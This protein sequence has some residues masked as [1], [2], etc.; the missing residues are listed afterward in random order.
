MTVFTRKTIITIAGFASIFLAISINGALSANQKKMPPAPAKPQHPVVSVTQVAAISKQAEITAYGEVSSRN[1]LSITS[2]VDG[3]IVYISPKFLTGNTFNQGEVLLEIEPIAYQQ[4]LADALVTLAD[5]ELVLAQEQLNSE[6]AKEEWLQSEL[7]TEQASDLVLRKPQ[8][9]VAKANVAMANAAVAKAKYDLTQTKLVAPFNALV[10]SKDVQI[11]TNIQMGT[12][13][14]QLY[15]ISLF[16]VSLPLSYQ[17]WQ[18]LPANNPHALTTINVELTDENNG[19]KWSAKVDRFEQHIDS[20]S[21]QRSLI[22]T[23]E[24]PIDFTDPLFPGTFIKASITGKPV[25]QLWKLPASALINNNTVWQVNDKGLLEH[26]PIKVI[27]SQNNAVYVK[28][29]EKLAQAKIVNR[30][31]SSYLLNMKVEAKIEELM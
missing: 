12:T 6:Q 25:E 27:F 30:P 17:Q 1:Q 23:V 18:L 22:A 4:N 31:L 16:E 21:R 24:R 15:D 28:P 13:L 19:T 11:G 9:A 20:Q 5:A 29:I 7:A 14:A 26:L 8:L 2:Q 3:H 10:V